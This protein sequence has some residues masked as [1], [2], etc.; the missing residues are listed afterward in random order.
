[1]WFKN[2][3]FIF[4]S[5]IISNHQ[6]HPAKIHFSYKNKKLKTTL[7]SSKSK[8]PSIAKILNKG[9]PL[10]KI[11]W[12]ADKKL[13]LNQMDGSDYSKIITNLDHYIYYNNWWKMEKAYS[14][15]SVTGKVTHF[16]DELW[17]WKSNARPFCYRIRT[18]P[19]RLQPLEPSPAGSMN[20]IL[21]EDWLFCGRRAAPWVCK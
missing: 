9:R 4:S 17:R 10:F 13:P 12:I 19:A 5:L 20:L 3:H 14:G 16:C 8:P 6:F 11:W 7:F 21:R 1:M 18:L 15:K 2:I